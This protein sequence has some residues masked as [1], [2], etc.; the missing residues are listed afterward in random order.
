MAD[1]MQMPRLDAY[2]QDLLRQSYGQSPISSDVLARFG[3]GMMQQAAPVPQV[4]SYAPQQTMQPDPR[5]LEY[6]KRVEQRFNELAQTVGGMEELIATGTVDIARQRALK[7]VE[8]LYGPAPSLPQPLQVQPIPGTNRVAVSGGGFS[9]PQMIEVQPQQAGM[10]F[11]PVFDPEGKPIPGMG[12]TPSGE[13]R[14]FKTAQ[15]SQA[16]G[17]KLNDIL[18]DAVQSID[19]LIGPKPPD[20]LSKENPAQKALRLSKENDIAWAASSSGD[21]MNFISPVLKSETTGIQKDIQ[22]LASKVG[23]VGATVFAGQGSFSDAERQM[24]KDSLSSINLGGTDEQAIASLRDLQRRLYEIK[25]RSSMTTNNQQQGS[26]SGATQT[27][28]VNREQWDGKMR[29]QAQ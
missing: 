16:E 21:F 23:A 24:I 1:P 11:T 26:Q 20:D 3:Q 8:M 4:E 9:S 5:R 12:M 22:N 15:E 28:Q 27:P 17:F 14:T 2:A 10:Q 19:K 29:T 7:D 13:I 6:A 25:Q 18:N